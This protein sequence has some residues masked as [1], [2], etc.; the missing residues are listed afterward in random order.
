MKHR[1]AQTIF[2][3]G[4]FWALVQTMAVAGDCVSHPGPLR[5]ESDTVQWSIVIARGDECIQGLRGKTMVFESLSFIEQPKTGRVVLQG[6]SFHYYA[7]ADAGS[8]SFR[9]LIVGSSMRMRGASTVDV[10][11][12][13][14]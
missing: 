2:A 10:V 4:L 13:V 9:L 12:Q 8:D 3:T 7:G 1:P 5:L 6:P 14:R 11:V